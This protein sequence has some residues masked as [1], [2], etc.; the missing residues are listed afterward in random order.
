MNNLNTRLQKFQGTLI[1]LFQMVYSHF[2]PTDSFHR[3]I[4]FCTG[5]VPGGDSKLSRRGTRSRDE[6]MSSPT[7]SAT[8]FLFWVSRK[9]EFMLFMDNVELLLNQKIFNCESNT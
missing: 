6:V 1:D 2:I 3:N 4:G 8:V 5:E 7:R 9:H